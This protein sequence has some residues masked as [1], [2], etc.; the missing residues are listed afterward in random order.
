MCVSL[1]VRLLTESLQIAD[2][3]PAILEA[4]SNVQL[5]CVGPV[6]DL[7]GKFAALKLER[8]MQM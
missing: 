3:F 2:V 8:L 4:N 1:T 7:Y 5:I 6:I